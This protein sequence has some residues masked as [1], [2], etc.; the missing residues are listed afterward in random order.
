M[1]DTFKDIEITQTDLDHR[2]L[3][4]A[5]NKAMENHKQN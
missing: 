2:M 3:I 5:V 4:L 1:C